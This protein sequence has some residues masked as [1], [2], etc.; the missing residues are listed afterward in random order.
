MVTRTVLLGFLLGCHHVAS[1]LCSLMFCGG[2]LCFFR[3]SLKQFDRFFKRLLRR[4]ELALAEALGATF[5]STE[6]FL[7]QGGR[8][9]RRSFASSAFPGFA[10]LRLQRRHATA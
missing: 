2:G 7:Q 6:S 3:R 8:P 5:L 1:G 4:G 9:V 10:C